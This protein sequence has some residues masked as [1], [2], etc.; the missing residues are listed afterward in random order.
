MRKLFLGVAAIALM[1]ANVAHADA[2]ADRKAIMK[3]NGAQMGVLGKTAKG[4]MAF[5][6]AIAL[7][8]F[9]S[10]REGIEGFGEL[11]PAGSETGGE[12]TASPKIWEDMEGFQAKLAKFKGDL[13]A[14]ITAAPADK[15]AFI[16]VF[17]PVASNCQSCHE[18]FRV[19]KK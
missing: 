4:E 6:A 12:T 9:N 7:A 3:N 15:D 17:A 8:A 16:A 13:D 10:M 14:A 11:F 5:D 1:V 18:E 2:I 19:Q